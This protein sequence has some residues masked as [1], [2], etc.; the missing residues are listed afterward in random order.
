[1]FCMIISGSAPMRSEIDNAIMQL[2][3][4][5][6]SGLFSVILYMFGI[7]KHAA[8]ALHGRELIPV[9]EVEHDRRRTGR[10]DRHCLVVFHDLT[11]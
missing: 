10:L 6:A 8:N 2:A 7:G 3:I 9:E 1:M 5:F 4:A 11:R